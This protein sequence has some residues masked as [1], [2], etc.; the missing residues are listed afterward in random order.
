MSETNFNSGPLYTLNPL[1]RF[2]DRA[3]DYVKYRP[4]YPAAAIDMIV[5]GLGEAAVVADIGAGTGISSRLL[6]DH[7]LRVLAIEPNAAMRTAAE[8]HPLVDFCD[9]KAEDT[10]LAA[11]SI[12]LVTCFQAFHWFDPGTRSQGLAR[13][14]GN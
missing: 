6:A 7:G 8:S 11:D 9:G 12:D 2:S 3:T 5:A 1:G 13:C 10:Q 14:V 4:S